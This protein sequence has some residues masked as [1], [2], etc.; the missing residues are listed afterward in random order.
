MRIYILISL[1]FFFLLPAYSVDNGNLCEN[2]KV[3]SLVL[4]LNKHNVDKE[5]IRKKLKSTPYESVGCLINQIQVVNPTIEIGRGETVKYSKSY[6]TVTTIRTLQYLTGIRMT[7]P[8]SEVKENFIGENTVIYQA[9]LYDE[10]GVPFFYIWESRSRIFFSPIFVQNKIIEQWR[11]W[12]FEVGNIYQYPDYVNPN[13][14]S[15]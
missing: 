12:Y 6:Y 13:F 7:V 3:N 4:E 11:N 10:S 9:E 5:A 8:L 2:D 1:T 15:F 14:W